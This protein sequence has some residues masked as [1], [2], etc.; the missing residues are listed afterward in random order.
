MPQAATPKQDEQVKDN[1]KA[2]EEVAPL[3]NYDELIDDT[4]AGRQIARAI[5]LER[6][7]DELRVKV[8]KN[9]DYLRLM[10][11]NEELSDDQS[12]WLDT[13]YPEKEKGARRS[14]D[15]I[16]ATRKAR[17]QSRKYA[18]ATAGSAS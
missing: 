13:Y 15:E 5:E 17:E 2:A 10:D 12:E 9:R 4:A 18:P 1:G 16:E 8:G 14:T 3:F 6:Q 11:A 7:L